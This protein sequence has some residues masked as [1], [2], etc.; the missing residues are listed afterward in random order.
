MT[1][2]L[3]LGFERPLLDELTGALTGLRYSI[4]TQPFHDDWLAQ[5]ESHVIFC[6]GDD[7][8]FRDAIRQARRSRPDLPMV[9]VTRLPEV[10]AW[11]DAL[12]A[13]ATDYC[14][15]PFE[16][17]QMRWVLDSAMPKP[18]LAAA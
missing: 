9:V 15:A 3:L 10:S 6:C 1:K 4:D 5:T 7:P 14:A 12:E 18:K 2:V 8:H 17:I 16:P 11:L 13:G